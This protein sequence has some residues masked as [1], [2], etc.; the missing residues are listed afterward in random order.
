MVADKPP[1][2]APNGW[3]KARLRGFKE[4]SRE[5]LTEVYRAHAPEVGALLR[6]GF[7]F[8]SGGVR[9]RFVGY[10]RGF[11]LQDALHETFRRAFEP[12]ARASYDGIRPYGPYIKTIAKNLVL[13][14]FRAREVSFP[15]DPVAGGEASRVL[16]LTDESP[17]PERAVHDQQVAGL[18]AAFLADL[19]AADR[20]LTASP[21][22]R[23]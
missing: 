12:K 22:R 4:G 15:V 23:A 18:V 19:S 17:T 20:R 3:T 10:R 1:Q 2:L 6:E 11:E 13:R 14:S 5:A 21:G 16:I 9:H 8:E 7:A